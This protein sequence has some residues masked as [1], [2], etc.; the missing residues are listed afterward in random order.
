MEDSRKP[1]AT[2]NNSSMTPMEIDPIDGG[3]LPTSIPTPTASAT[4]GPMMMM[5]STVNTPSPSALTTPVVLTQEEQAQQVIEALRKADDMAQRVAAAH[6]LPA[7]AALLG[8]ERTRV[9][10]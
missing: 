8:P 1:Q 5:L 6:Q 2:S 10:C 9:V 7:V 3:P 4:G